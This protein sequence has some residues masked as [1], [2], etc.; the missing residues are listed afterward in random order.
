MASSIL[1]RLKTLDSRRV[2][3][4][5]CKDEYYWAVPMKEY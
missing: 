4:Y 5:T 1:L 3:L 2:S